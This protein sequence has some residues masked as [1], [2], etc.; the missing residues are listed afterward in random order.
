MAKKQRRYLT[1]ED[2][3]RYR[4]HQSQF[5][6]YFHVSTTRIVFWDVATAEDV[7]DRID[8]LRSADGLP[9]AKEI[10]NEIQALEAKRAELERASEH[11]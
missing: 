4:F 6:P 11:R 3:S 1:A 9:R 2:A 5:R 8:Y 7:Q 10:E